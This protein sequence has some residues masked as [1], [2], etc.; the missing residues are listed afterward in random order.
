MVSRT[1]AKVVLGLIQAL[2][3]Y[4]RASDTEILRL[5][6]DY[7]FTE[8][9][10]LELDACLHLDPKGVHDR[11]VEASAKIA[12]QQVQVDSPAGPTA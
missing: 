8:L 4:C 3:G 10:Y 6:K 5:L 1:D 12:Q 7:L 2:A 9:E 11:I